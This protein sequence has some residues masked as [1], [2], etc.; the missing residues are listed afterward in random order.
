[1][2]I[3][4]TIKSVPD[5]E[6][7]VKLKVD[8]SGLDFT[9]VKWVI[10]PFDEIATEEAVRKKGK[11]GCEV[12][13]LSIGPERCIDQIRQALAMGADRGI[14]VVTDEFLDPFTNSEIIA[15][16]YEQE[17]P[18]IVLMGKQA[19]DDDSNQTGQ[20]LS[21]RLAIPQAC[22]ASSIDIDEGFTKAT[23]VREVDGGLE[24]K[25]IKLP[26]IITAD[27]RL[28]E[29]RYPSLLEIMKAKKKP[30][31]EIKLEELGIAPQV[32][33]LILDYKRPPERPAGEIIPDVSTL[34]KKLIEEKVL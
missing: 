10:N 25:E 11:T 14:H 9:G 15:K 18:Q 17:K 26:A 31:T 19:I 2:K 24:T 22:F 33:T 4:A 6:V 12:V 1:M 28:N 34:V 29:P 23:V 20:M 8:L 21:E 27:L 16:I 13:V 7:K 5:P 30:V 32:T 3:L